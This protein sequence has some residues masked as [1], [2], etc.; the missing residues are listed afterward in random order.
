MAKGVVFIVMKDAQRKRLAGMVGEQMVVACTLAASVAM[1]ALG[2]VSSCEAGGVVGT[3]WK[4]A[5][6]DGACPVSMNVRGH[7]NIEWSIAYAYGLTDETKDLPR[8]LLVGD[9][10]CNGYQSD[11]RNRLKDWNGETPQ[12]RW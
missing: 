10:I 1:A 8:V 9:S 11:V 5:D 2:G 12:L 7:E 6:E 3:G 4:F